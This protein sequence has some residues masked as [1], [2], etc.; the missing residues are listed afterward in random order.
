MQLEV[1]QKFRIAD[2]ADL[3]HRLAQQEVK[4]GEAVAQVDTYFLHPARDFRQ[5]DEAFRL[6]QIGASNFLTYK[7][8]KIDSHTKTRRELELPLASGVE[9]FHLYVE[10][11]EALGFGVGGVVRKYRRHGHWLGDGRGIDVA[12]DDVEGLGTFLELE[13]VVDEGELDAAR[14]SICAFAESLGLHQAERRSYLE[15]LQTSA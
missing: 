2:V 14:R 1:E 13:A 5:T 7:G 10:M 11:F 8:P 12:W 15:L 4:L 3:Q 9:L 6:R